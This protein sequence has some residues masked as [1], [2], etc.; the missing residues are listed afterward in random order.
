[1]SIMCSL[2]RTEKRF[3]RECEKCNTLELFFNLKVI[4][5]IDEI[6]FQKWIA[7]IENSISEKPH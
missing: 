2:N 4:E 7:K 6:L 5:L 1:M 3:P